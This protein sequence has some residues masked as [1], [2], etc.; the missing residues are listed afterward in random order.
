MAKTEK[1]EGQRIVTP[2]F[3][4]SYPHL[5]KPQGMKGA[6]PKYSVT[7]L[8]KKDQDLTKIKDAMKAA[9]VAAFGPDKKKWP[10]D[11]ESPVIDGDIP[12]YA[13]REGYK[14]HYAIK[15][16]TNP[17]SKPGVVDENREEII[18]PSEFYP[19]CYARAQVFCR[20]WEFSGKTGI[21]FILD[22]VQKL[23]DG[24]Q[25][26]G[27]KSAK[28]AFAPHDEEESNDSEDESNDEN[29]GF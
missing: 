26:G 10:A 8:F 28:E 9:K 4:A 20:V 23:G 6:E 15:A 2:K 16:S 27:K 7:M 25:F 13:D 3:R 24:K 5:F 17:D 21:H 11:I 29:E 12:K 19:G 22:H 1:N 14:G 18:D